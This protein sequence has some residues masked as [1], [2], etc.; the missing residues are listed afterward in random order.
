MIPNKESLDCAGQLGFSDRAGSWMQV[1]DCPAF[2]ASGARWVRQRPLFLAL[3]VSLNVF[4]LH[5]A[6]LSTTR[7]LVLLG[8]IT[9]PFATAVFTA[10]RYEK[11]TP[12]SLF[13]WL[14][15]GNVFMVTAIATTGGVR[16]PMLPMLA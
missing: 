7:L 5:R 16:S 8:I 6:G 10:L 12:K 3:V 9:V 2:G 4:L 13:V 15:S 11:L 14:A 1:G